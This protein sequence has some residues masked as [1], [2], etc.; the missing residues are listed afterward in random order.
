MAGSGHYLTRLC[1]KGMPDLIRPFLASLKISHHSCGMIQP[2]GEIGEQ[3]ESLVAFILNCKA[4]LVGERTFGKGLIQSVFE[5]RDGSGVVVTVGK[6][7]TP[8]HLDINGN[9]IVPD[10]RNFPAAWSDIAQHLSRCN[11]LRRSGFACPVGSSISRKPPLR[12]INRRKQSS[13]ESRLLLDPSISTTLLDNV[14]IVNP[15]TPGTSPNPTSPSTEPSTNPATPITTPTAPTTNP[16]TPTTTPTTPTTTPT[17]QNP[18]PSTS[19]GGSWCIANQGASTTALQV[20]LDYACGYGGADCSAIQPG[21][22]CYEPSTVQNHA[23]YAFNDYYQKHPDPTSCVFGGTAQLT[24]TD[25]SN[26]NCHYAASSPTGVT[27]PASI[28]PPATLPPPDISTMTP[29]FAM[30]PP[31]TG[32]GGDTVYGSAEPTGLPSSAS[33]MSFSYVLIFATM[34]LLVAYELGP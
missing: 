6:Y 34:S 15:T 13:Q 18:T 1:Q 11:L 22:S 17:T 33:S 29:P 16:T 31:F 10:Y 27:P 14:P 28:T 8:S 30:S 7:E 5:L 21:G 2:H 12:E 4:V 20:A 3:I 32:P 24:N 25:P 26:G 9:G 23:S 19:S